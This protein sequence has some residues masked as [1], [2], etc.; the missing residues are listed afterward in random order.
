M[1]H[2]C[3]HARIG[4]PAACQQLHVPAP[5]SPPP[6]LLP[7]S[8]YHHH[9]IRTHLAHSLTW[10]HRTLPQVMLEM[11]NYA[12]GLWG[13]REINVHYMLRRAAPAGGGG[14]QHHAGGGMQMQMHAPL[15]QELSAHEAADEVGGRAAAERPSAQVRGINVV[16]AASARI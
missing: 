16:A 2:A 4:Q 15:L 14:A 6:P 8:R 12:G 1:L 9:H 7:P 3:P 10:L 5:P 11:D 13:G